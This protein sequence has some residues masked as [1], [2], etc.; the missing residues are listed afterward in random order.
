MASIREK[1]PYQF[2]AQIRR[3]GWPQQ[4]NTFRTRKETQ[5]WAREIKHEMDQGVKA[6][7]VLKSHWPAPI[8]AHTLLD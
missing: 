4:S 6:Y 8:R 7:I 3:K 2:H 5:A 1:G